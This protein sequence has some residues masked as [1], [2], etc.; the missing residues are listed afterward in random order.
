VAHATAAEPILLELARRADPAT[1]KRATADIWARVNPVGAEKALH[2]AYARRG[3]T[4][5]VVGQLGY[6][7]GVFDLEATA[8]IA[9]ALQPLL[10]PTGSDDKRD[11]PQ[12]RADALVDILQHYLDTADVPQL[13]R[14]RPHVSMII[15][16][17]Q[18]TP[19]G[20]RSQA[21]VDADGPAGGSSRGWSG[22]VTLPW[23]GAAV[24]ASIVRRWT[25]DAALSPVL[26]R[27]LRRGQPTALTVE[28]AQALAGT[29]PG[30]SAPSV[31]TLTLDSVVWMPLSVGR[32]QRT[33]T[34]AQITALRARDAGCIQPECTRTAA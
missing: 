33:A 22:T 9:T 4:L 19:T 24:P 25:C 14:R 21:G 20:D 13:G 31:T 17:D 3:L 32:T 26:A 5:S 7:D 16:A 8:L 30:A 11:T 1:V 6:L 2:Q 18:L 23:T 10:A 12:R 28:E 15:N 27:L 34:T 29:A